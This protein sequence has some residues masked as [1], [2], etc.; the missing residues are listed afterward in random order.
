VRAPIEERFF[1]AKRSLIVSLLVVATLVILP[2][3]A[4]AQG[5][6]VGGG[7]S[8][9]T[10]DFGTDGF[11]VG[12]AWWFTD[13]VSIA[14]DYDSTWDASSLSNFA[15]I[16]IGGI[17]INSHLQS[18]LTGPRVT[19]KTGWTDQHKLLPFAEAEFGVSHL[20]QKLTQVGQPTNSASDTAFAWMVGGGVDYMLS[21][22]WSARGNLDFLRTHFAN[23]GQSR[24][25]LVLGV[26]YIFGKRQ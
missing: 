13:R 22:H 5:L 9:V 14:A 25:R 4:R 20:N 21:S 19:F 15:F 1:S 12:G 11:N 17:A 3:G 26:R 24:L 6:E 18:F 2:S 8:H 7:W 10:N 16:E 23:Q